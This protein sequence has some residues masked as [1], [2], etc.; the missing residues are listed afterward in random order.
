MARPEKVSPLRKLASHSAPRL[1]WTF[2]TLRRGLAQGE[3]VGRADERTLHQRDAAQGP[4]AFDRLAEYHQL[5]PLVAL[6][7][8]DRERGGVADW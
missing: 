8:V 6:N 7:A 3:R 4:E 2:G 5:E 1:S